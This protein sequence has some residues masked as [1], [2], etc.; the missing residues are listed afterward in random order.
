[1]LKA[2]DEYA[3]VNFSAEDVREGMI[4]AVAIELKD[5]LRESDQAQAGK[6]RNRTWVAEDV[7]KETSRASQE[8]SGGEEAA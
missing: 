5:P 4:G 6:Q 1:M 7:K 8:R 2:I 3:G